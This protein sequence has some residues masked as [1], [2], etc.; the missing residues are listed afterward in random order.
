MRQ[1]IVAAAMVAAVP[2]SAEVKTSTANGFESVHVATVAAPPE[3]V[4]QALGQPV[5]WWNKDHTYSG[6]AVN[7]SLGTVAG[8]CFCEK[9]PADGSTIEHGRT[10]YAQPGKTLRVAG[11]LGPLQAEGVSAALTWTLKP[12]GAG[13]EVTQTYV[14]GGYVRGGAD[15]LAP[16]VDR[17][18]GEQLKGLKAHFDKR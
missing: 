15:K 14:V 2:A 3:R 5:L 7:L 1:I 4:F 12:L 16:I 10:V 18:L 8:G 11:A 6:D 13:T 17:V 9:V